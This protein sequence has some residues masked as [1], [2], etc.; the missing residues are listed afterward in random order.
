MRRQR[1]A[2]ALARQL[3]AEAVNEPQ[4]DVAMRLAHEAVDLDRSPQTESSLLSTILRSPAV[5]GT[6]SVPGERRV[7]SRGEP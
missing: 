3:G 4:I 6:L 5:T 1:H 2:I 7:R